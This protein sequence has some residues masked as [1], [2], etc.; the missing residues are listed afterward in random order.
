M[1]TSG[2]MMIGIIIN[3]DCVRHSLAGTGVAE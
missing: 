1:T 2:I 3:Q